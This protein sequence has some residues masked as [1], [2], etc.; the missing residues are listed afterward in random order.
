MK[1]S[2][3]TEVTPA[4][5][6]IRDATQADG[7]ACAGIYAPYVTDTVITFETE[8]PLAGDMAA[9]ARGRR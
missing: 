5:L 8:V 7:E 9:R 1:F 2:P 6:S 4:G 3:G